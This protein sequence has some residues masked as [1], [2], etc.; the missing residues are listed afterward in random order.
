MFYPQEEQMD[1]RKLAITL[2][3]WLI[4]ATASLAQ[5]AIQAQVLQRDLRVFF[6]SDF[7]FTGRGRATSEIFAVQIINGP[8][9]Q[10]YTLRLAISKDSVPLAEGRTNPFSMPPAQVIRIT[11]ANLFSQAQQFSL[12][13]YHILADGQ[14]MRDQILAT[15]KLP[16]GIYR[17]DFIVLLNGVEQDRTY[18]EIDITN[19]SSLDL[20]GPG[21]PAGRGVP[22][23]SLTPFPFFR[24]TS[25]LTRFRLTVA[26]KLPMVHDSA[27]PAEIIQD[28]VRFERVVSL[29]PAR[30]GSI[31]ADGTEYTATTSYLYP[32]A[33]VWPLEQG[34]SYYWQITGLV[35]GSGVETELPSEIWAFTIQE[36]GGLSLSSTS[37]LSELLTTLRS[38]S[39]TDM[40]ASFG[41]GGE[42][43]GF[44]MT[45][46]FW[47]NGSWI[48]YEQL[49][50]I[51]LKLASGEY[52]ILETRVE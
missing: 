47:L 19:P 49:Q 8:V 7:N 20:I 24:W 33:G 4:A 14:D 3:V 10:N 38:D 52:T 35:P 6:L 30:T 17:F 44:T 51:L 45:G 36:S 26:E 41:E 39:G 37:R 5:V 11:N 2:M 32:A 50:A 31:A 46:R 12:D 34:K 25:N 27:S 18:L 22:G 1:G 9:T 29:D 28:R 40:G 43:D 23:I 42:L 48:T 13:D 16:S 21:T 15:G